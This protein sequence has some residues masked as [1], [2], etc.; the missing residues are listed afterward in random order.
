[1]ERMKGNKDSLVFSVYLKFA[2][3][4]ELDWQIGSFYLQLTKSH[5]AQKKKK[6]FGVKS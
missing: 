3:I 4:E 1:M 2:L 6:G 5:S